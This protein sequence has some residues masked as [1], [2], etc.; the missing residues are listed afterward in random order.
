MLKPD[1][2]KRRS[3]QPPPLKTGT[4]YNGCGATVEFRYSP[5][6]VCVACKTERQLKRWRDAAEVQRRKRGVAPVKGI[7]DS[8]KRCGSIYT[9]LVAHGKY[10]DPCK[11]EAP[12]DRARRVALAKKGVPGSR[13]YHTR[14]YKEKRHSDPA[15]AIN[16]RMRAAVRRV[17]NGGK[18]GRKWEALVGYQLADLMAHL[19]AQ[20]LPGMSWDNRGEWHIDHIRPLCSFEFETPEDPQFREAWALTNLQP[21]WA[22]DNIRKG[23]RWNPSA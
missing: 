19:E 18:R 22:G 11:A 10:C 12:R 20:F 6:V 7:A 5:R 1:K 3:P 13:D 9:K 15:Y 21:L 17:L 23:G 2:P 4:C 8:C 14:W 16:F